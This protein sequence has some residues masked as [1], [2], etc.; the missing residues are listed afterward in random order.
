MKDIKFIPYVCCGD[1]NLEFTYKLIRTL[2]PYSEIIELGIPFS[3]PIADGKTIQ[4]AANRAL[5]SGTTV[6]QIF[7]M[8]GQLRKDGIIVPFVFMTYFNIVYSYGSECFLKKMREI[9]VQGVIIPDLPFEEDKDFEKL[10]ESCGVSM[11]NLIA[12]NTSDERAK[13][14]L[15]KRCNVL[16][17][18]LVSIAGTTGTRDNASIESIEFVRKM[19]ALAGNDKKLYVGFGISTPQQATEFVNAGADG[20]IIGSAL[21]E[22]YS[23]HIR[24]R[25]IDEELVLKDVRAFGRTFVLKFFHS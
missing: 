9:G 22:I 3:D 12:P 16:F 14:I 1:P 21:I 11:V 19:R 5:T 7:G 24:D 8:V 15:E 25:K 17:T 4:A 13:K 6:E 18:Y 2:A 10:A 23:K 20:V